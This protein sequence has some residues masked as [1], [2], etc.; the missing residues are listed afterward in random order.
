MNKR[1]KTRRDTI[2]KR[3]GMRCR[4][5]RVKFDRSHLSK[6]KK[7][8]LNRL[9]LEAK[10]LYNSILGSD[11]VFK[12]DTKL[13]NIKIKVKDKFE[14]RELK[15]IS[16]QM[17]QGIHTR[18]CNSIKSLSR[19]EKHRRGKL[20]FKSRV[21]S[22][23]LKQYNATYRIENSK[24]IYLQ[25]F[26][27]HFKV[28]GLDQIPERCDI[29]NATLIKRDD[30]YY[31]HIT[32]YTEKEKRDFDEESVGIDF[33]IK[34]TLVLSSG[35]KFKVDIP[36]S[37]KTKSL[38]RKLKNKKK[39]SNNYCKL[40]KKIR[41]SQRKTVNRKKDIKNKI[42][43]SVVT[44]YK[45]ICV[46]DKSIKQWK[47]GFFGKQV[48]NSILGGIMSD[49]KRRSHTFKTVDKYFPTTQICNSCHNRQNMEL[50]D[51]VYKC[52]NCGAEE[53]RD[54]N[55]A[56]NIEDAGTGRISKMPVEKT[57][58]VQE[59]KLISKKQEASQL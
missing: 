37:E 8:Y 6:E 18:I 39:G 9:F 58:A 29:T 55:S 51:R 22:L 3:K 59:N 14:T 24:Y 11:D 19:K 48:H 43:H 17:K 47:D 7:E 46:Q 31:I 56:K 26:R 53:D 32:V 4:V 38:R 13:N 36:E 42:V 20:K 57:T 28:M 41:K 35:E 52:S 23:P 25:K 45:T 5:F 21:W 54:V 49:L 44:K 15:V 34:D 27:K 16:S 33:G 12:Y 10:W 50:S 1:I 40:W 2:N 30:D